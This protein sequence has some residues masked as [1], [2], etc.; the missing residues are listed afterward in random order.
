VPWLTWLRAGRRRRRRR[1]AWEAELGAVA[2]AVRSQEVRLTDKV[3]A[4]EERKLELDHW[5]RPPHRT[6]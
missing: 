3:E 6:A 4:A 2:A 1:Q 5:V